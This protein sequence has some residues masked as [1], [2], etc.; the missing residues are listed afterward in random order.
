[1][2]LSSQQAETALQELLAQHKIEK[3]EHDSKVFYRASG[4]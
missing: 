2:G 1:L 3:T 4:R